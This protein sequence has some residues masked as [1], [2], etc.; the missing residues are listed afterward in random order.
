MSATVTYETL[1]PRVLD[2]GGAPTVFV[3]AMTRAFGNPPWR[4]SNRDERILMGL[5]AARPLIPAL[6][7][8]I[9]KL[10]GE[11]ELLVMVSY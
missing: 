7:T 4:L 11:N 3:E 6:T 10:G 2:T 5:R 8:L 1:A 9:E